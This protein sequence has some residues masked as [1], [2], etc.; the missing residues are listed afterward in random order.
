MRGLFG[1]LRTVWKD[2]IKTMTF[3]IYFGNINVI[4]GRQEPV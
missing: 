2:N 4:E 3:K 1:G